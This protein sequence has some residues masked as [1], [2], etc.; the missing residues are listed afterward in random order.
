MVTTTLLAMAFRCV[1]QWSLLSTSLIVLPLWFVDLAFWSSNMT[2]I[3]SGGWVPLALAVVLVVFMLTFKWGRRCEQI[4]MDSN[5]EILDP[6]V[7]A[8]LQRTDSVS[9]FLTPDTSRM[10]RC[11]RIMIQASNTMSKVVVLLSVKVSHD[12]IIP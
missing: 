11:L 4:V 5:R 1:W 7:L 8:T 3:A 2:K 12:P 6:E 10:P 9:V